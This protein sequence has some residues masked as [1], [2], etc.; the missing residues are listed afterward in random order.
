[1]LAWLFIFGI[2]AAWA[3]NA[4]AVDIYM[5]DSG[6]Y[7]VRQHCLQSDVQVEWTWRRVENKTRMESVRVLDGFTSLL[8]ETQ[9]AR[10][11]SG[12]NTLKGGLTPYS[13]FVT[14]TP[15][16]FVVHIHTVEYPGGAPQE[17]LSVR[18]ARDGSDVDSRVFV[19]D[20]ATGDVSPL[21]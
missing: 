8:T 21:P 18:F 6:S 7:S 9:A 4:G 12:I 11:L 2:V 17:E 13:A 3:T 16:G 10:I 1:M 20:P 14:C 5:P 19:R 15:S